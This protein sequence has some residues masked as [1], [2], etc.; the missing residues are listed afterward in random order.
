M[1]RLGCLLPNVGTAEPEI[2]RIASGLSGQ[3]PSPAIKTVPSNQGAVGTE[4]PT[5]TGSSNAGIAMG[6]N[7]APPR[8][9]TPLADR[10]MRDD[11]LAAPPNE[12][13]L[14]APK[15][16]ALHPI[17]RLATDGTPASDR[18]MQTSVFQ[19]R[20]SRVLLAVFLC[21]DLAFVA[22]FATGPAAS[23]GKYFDMAHIALAGGPTDLGGPA[24]GA[25]RLSF[26]ENP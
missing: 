22:W 13:R 25:A 15:R 9:G 4:R 7:R 2:K 19:S 21:L 18:N 6:A 23:A 8:N 14:P 16:I 11:G 24:N 5:A 3:L 26:G 12:G 17:D 20:C 1:R 10:T